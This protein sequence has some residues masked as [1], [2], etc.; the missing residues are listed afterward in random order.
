M[1]TRRVPEAVTLPDGAEQPVGS[2]A[3]VA[4]GIVSWLIQRNEL[5]RLP[6]QGRSAF[7][8]YFLNE[9]PEHKD[10]ANGQWIP[11]RTN[12]KT[13]YMSGRSA[14]AFVLVLSELCDAAGRP[15]MEFRMRLRE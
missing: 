8:R 1:V 5:P 2:W 12:G 7:N 10:G 6:F 15:A 13:I 14:R 3:D 4:R 9:A 11:V